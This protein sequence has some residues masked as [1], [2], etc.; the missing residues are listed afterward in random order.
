M[1]L[2]LGCGPEAAEGF[3]GVDIQPGPGVSYLCDLTQFPWTMRHIEKWDWPA[4]FQF[5]PDSVEGARSS[6]LVEHLP[7]LVGFMQ[8][9]HRVMKPGA[10][11]EI[12]HPYQFNVRAWQ[13]PTHVRCL[14]EVSWFYFDKEWRGGAEWGGYGDTDFKLVELDAIPMPDWQKVADEHPDEF[15]KAAKSLLNVISDLRVVLECRK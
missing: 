9:L 3:L 6:H 7:D 12:Q 4:P 13:D 8:E 2:D 15:E 10:L 1:F 5:E 14:N 11:I